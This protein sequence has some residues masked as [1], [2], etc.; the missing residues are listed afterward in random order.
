MRQN[1]QT[2]VKFSTLED[3]KAIAKD[4]E[5][6]VFG[7]ENGVSGNVKKF[8]ELR[9][10]HKR[11]GQ[12][13]ARFNA[14][15]EGIQQIERLREERVSQEHPEAYESLMVAYADLCTAC[16]EYI[17]SSRFRFT[18]VGRQRAE[19][20]KEVYANAEKEVLMIQMRY[21]EMGSQFK[22]EGITLRQLF[23]GETLPQLIQNDAANFS[24]NE[25]EAGPAAKAERY[26][27]NMSAAAFKNRVAQEARVDARDSSVIAILL[28]YYQRI[29]SRMDTD[30]ASEDLVPGIVNSNPEP[31]RRE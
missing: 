6:S 26:R 1:Y 2:D 13:S 24:L 29:L 4:Y 8:Q 12:N 28:E 11:H 5:Q 31:M 18:S 19:I 25:S 17:D 10:T 21:F 30:P 7:K 20:V 16:K 14:V 22:G 9:A 15:L 27:L 3:A 23:A